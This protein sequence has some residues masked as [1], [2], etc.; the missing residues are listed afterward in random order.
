MSGFCIRLFLTIIQQ[1][2]KAFN[3]VGIRFYLSNP[4]PGHPTECTRC[5][6]EVVY[7]WSEATLRPSIWFHSVLGERIACVT[8][9]VFTVGFWLLE[10]ASGV[11]SEPSRY[12]VWDVGLGNKMG[13]F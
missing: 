10:K 9:L 7:S 13:L 8:I 1:S 3:N 5:T 6:R 2:L 11:N 4:K 12:S